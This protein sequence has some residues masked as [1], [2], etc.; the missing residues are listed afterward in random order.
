MY[1]NFP[2]ETKID[3]IK[4]LNFNQMTVIQQINRHF[5]E[6]INKYLKELPRQKFSTMQITR[7]E[8]T[9]NIIKPEPFNFEMSEEL[10]RKWCSA[11]FGRV[12]ICYSYK[13]LKAFTI[14]FKEKG[15]KPIYLYL[16]IYPKNTL[17]MQILYCVFYQ[18]SQCFFEKIEFDRVVFNPKIFELLYDSDKPIQFLCGNILQLTLCKPL[19]DKNAFKLFQKNLSISGIVSVNAFS[20]H[21]LYTQEYE[22]IILEFLLKGGDQIPQIAINSLTLEINYFDKLINVSKI[23]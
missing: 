3:I 12:F 10:N 1:L 9:G 22:K 7:G 11:I 13:T 6:L 17:D 2:V 8:Y 20:N 15:C 21:R 23:L 4:C 18:L 19:F 16:P 5:F 14:K